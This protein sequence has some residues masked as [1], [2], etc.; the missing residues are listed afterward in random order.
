MTWLTTYSGNYFDY[1]NPDINSINIKDIAKALSH[2]CRFA[3]HLERFYSVAQ[4][5]VECSFI[6]P[7]QFALEA[8]LH[9]ATEAYCKDIPSPLKWLL[10]D[11]KTIE[12]N[13]NSIIRKKFGLSVFESREVKHADLVM[14]ATERRDLLVNDGKEWPILRGIESLDRKIEPL[15]NNVAFNRFM[16]RFEELTKEII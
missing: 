6:V 8:L 13:L 10:D 11:Y 5:C 4:H 7:K 1:L 14:L 16:R 2:E 3:G 9:D 15:P 12:K